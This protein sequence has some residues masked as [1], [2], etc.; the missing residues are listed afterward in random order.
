MCYPCY[1]QPIFLNKLKQN[2]VK[3]KYID[4]PIYVGRLG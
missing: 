3:N 1:A 4:V 2:G